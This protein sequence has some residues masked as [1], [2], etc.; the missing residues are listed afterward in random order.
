[1]YL[2]SNTDKQNA[3]S[4]ILIIKTLLEKRLKSVQFLVAVCDARCYLQVDLFLTSI[5]G[6]RKM[7]MHSCSGCV[8]NFSQR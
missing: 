4:L 3:L 7:Q 2:C 1:M 5:Y 8:S 6:L